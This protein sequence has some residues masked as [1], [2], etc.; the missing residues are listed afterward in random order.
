M[1]PITH[2]N[3]RERRGSVLLVVIFILVFVLLLTLIYVSIGRSDWRLRRAIEGRELES[4][5]KMRD[6]IAQVIADDAL[7]VFPEQS[8]VIENEPPV[9]YREVSD[10]PYVLPEVGSQFNAGDANADFLK[11]NPTGDFS[12]ALVDFN[13]RNFPDRTEAVLG[14]SDPWLAATL[15]TDLTPDADD[16]LDPVQGD[17]RPDI[18]VQRFDKDRD[19]W[20]ISNVAPDGLFVN[21]YALR[22]NYDA[23]AGFDPGQ[24]SA[25][26][27]LIKRD[28]D[29]YGDPDQTVQTPEFTNTRLDQQR[30]NR[31]FYWT[32][33][34]ENA[35]RPAK[36]TSEDAPYSSP[37]FKGYQWADADGDGMLDSRWFQAADSSTGNTTPLFG[38][39]GPYRYF[40]A[41]RVVDLSSLIN[42]NT[43]G[44]TTA[45]GE[46]A[47]KFGMP[48]DVDLTR[49]LTNLVSYDRYGVG[50]ETL[51]NRVGFQAEPEYYALY[52]D[53]QSASVGK[54]AAAAAQ[55]MRGSGKVLDTAGFQWLDQQFSEYVNTLGTAVTPLDPDLV[56]VIRAKWDFASLLGNKNRRDYYSLFAPRVYSPSQSIPDLD[57]NPNPSFYNFGGRYGLEST[58]ELNIFRG[59][60]RIASTSGLEATFAVR[61]AFEPVGNENTRFCPLRSNRPETDAA[62]AVD[63]G[64]VPNTIESDGKPDL[65]DLLHSKVD[66]RSA[67]TTVSGARPFRPTSGVLL[68]SLNTKEVKDNV[69]ELLGPMAMRLDDEAFPD[70]GTP[71]A[72][73]QSRDAARERAKSATQQLFNAY[74]S[75][76]DG[77]PRYDFEDAN[78]EIRSVIW[79]RAVQDR[80]RFDTAFYGGRGVPTMLRAAAHMSVNALD[81][82]DMDRP[83]PYDA[84][85]DTAAP[86]Q[87]LESIEPTVTQFRL[88]TRSA[89]DTSLQGEPNVLRL[90]LPP[91]LEAPNTTQP[92]GQLRL[93]GIEPQPFISQVAVFTTYSDLPTED[94]GQDEYEGALPDENRFASI[95]VDLTQSNRDFMYRVLAFKLVN[96]FGTPLD[97]N[98]LRNCF[99]RYGG[100]TY[101]IQSPELLGVS[102]DRTP[103]PPIPG[104]PPPPV[105]EANFNV[106]AFGSRV[107]YVMY[108]PPREDRVP[109]PL[110]YIGRAAKRFPTNPAGAGQP[111]RT[112]PTVDDIKAGIEATLGGST[113]Q[114]A[115]GTPQMIIAV[116]DNFQ[117]EIITRDF[118]PTIANAVAENEVQLWRSSTLAAQAPN[119]T[120]NP[121]EQETRGSGPTAQTSWVPRRSNQLLDR[122]RFTSGREVLHNGTK[123]A[124]SPSSLGFSRTNECLI[125]GSTRSD[126]NLSRVITLFSSFSRPVDPAIYTTWAQSN[127]SGPFGVPDGALPAYCLESKVDARL[128]P[129]PWNFKSPA[130]TPTSSPDRLNSAA[131]SSTVSTAVLQTGRFGGSSPNSWRTNATRVTQLPLESMALNPAYPRVAW[132]L[133]TGAGGVASRSITAQGRARIA[134]PETFYFNTFRITLPGHR[135]DRVGDTAQGEA[136]PARPGDLLMPLAFGPAYNYGTPTVTAGRLA[137]FDNEI[138]WRWATLGETAATLMGFFDYETEAFDADDPISLYKPDVLN[139]VEQV[140]LDRGQ[141]WL[142]RFAP[143]I[144]SNRNSVYEPLVDQPLGN[145]APLAMGIFD[146]FHGFDTSIVPDKS[147][148]LTSSLPGVVNLSTATSR[149]LESLP[150][151]APPGLPTDLDPNDASVNEVQRITYSPTSTDLSTVTVQLPGFPQQPQPTRQF[152]L[153]SGSA[154]LQEELNR[155][156]P[157]YAQV[158]CRNS[159]PASIDV[160]FVG[161]DVQGV[162]IPPMQVIG[163][164]GIIVTEVVNGAPGADFGAGSDFAG[165]GNSGWYDAQGK[166]GSV[167][168]AQTDIATTLLAYRDKTARQLRRSSVTGVS[169]TSSKAWFNWIDFDDRR[170]ESDEDVLP[171]T[172]RWFGSR[173]RVSSMALINEQPGFRSLAELIGV[174]VRNLPEIDLDTAVNNEVFP[175]LNGAPFN[176]DFIGYDVDGGSAAPVSAGTGG[177]PKPADFDMPGMVLDYYQA[178]APVQTVGTRS[179]RYSRPNVANSYEEQMLII[180][181]LADTVSTRSDLYIAWFVVHGYSEG[182]CQLDPRSNTP[183][184]PS[185]ARRYLMIVDRSNVIRRGDKPKILH[186]QEVPYAPF[187]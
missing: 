69:N 187:Q 96:P 35:F 125:I 56:P 13:E 112:A 87:Y 55:V 72:L 71:Q 127:P 24:L 129:V 102:T 3:G 78:A 49:A 46:R 81:M 80:R 144:D 82:R 128:Q 2:I 146:Y 59:L 16:V 22:G 120:F 179:V 74:T 50:Y 173:S 160:I 135:A 141:L 90:E 168:S 65:R 86:G 44:D 185:I 150:C 156:L 153:R 100:G 106:P 15:P 30:K 143:F 155:V 109:V 94:G 110:S 77:M 121:L 79:E 142:D 12:A 152:S 105:P 85:E 84:T 107:F 33:R 161:R 23:E 9:A 60:N 172:P 73:A 43:A 53:F 4:P 134:M 163:G 76:L 40:Y 18:P 113:A 158:R 57:G 124:P 26:L 48:G 117:E 32:M 88:T 174:R 34:Q 25:N 140:H 136:I 148:M 137:G 177:T 91:R 131:F 157:D 180:N 151:L 154:A 176:I 166:P 181:A 108:C 183:L 45:G 116:N 64:D 83:F 186:F 99:I 41:T 95:K 7:S 122:M 169:Q 97:S 62:Y 36:V 159:G 175:R 38:K 19:W 51:R 75:I 27:S 132:D 89:A 162:D 147:T 14:P 182:D 20:S 58:V 178:P 184:V 52:D 139:G 93:Y 130:L 145:A 67:L 167:L 68:D 47:F 70:A 118:F 54:A 138:R 6:Y 164:A 66:L 165:F 119:S 11:F 21:L 17:V 123:L 39:G 98:Y 133:S 170:I 37:D 31:P 61:Q 63:Q 114:G 8:E 42:V 111:G 126:V 10:Y 171:D 92:C 29:G 1:I 103:Q 104:L 115:S 5:E 101:R 149:T 28:N